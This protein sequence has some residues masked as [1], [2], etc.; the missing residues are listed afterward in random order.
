MT[1]IGAGWKKKDKNNNPY[2]SW[3]I[4]EAIQPL[5]INRGKML[6]AYPV[7]EKKN[8]NSPDFRLEL[9]CPKKQ[10]E[11]TDENIDD[12]FN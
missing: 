5:V 3:V 1:T 6:N 9:F 7:K 4:D 11:Q 8:E 12:L 10:E 2:I